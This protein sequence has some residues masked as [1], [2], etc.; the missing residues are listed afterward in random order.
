VPD[1]DK[2]GMKSNP[3]LYVRERQNSLQA[4][5]VLLWGR[6]APRF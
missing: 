2:Y 4:T 6:K 5:L 1:G 3:H